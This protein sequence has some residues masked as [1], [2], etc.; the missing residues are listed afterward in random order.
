MKPMK[1]RAVVFR[2][3]RRQLLTRFGAALG[4][5]SLGGCLS[6]YRDIAEDSGDGDGSGGD[7]GSDGDGVTDR[8]FT[9]TDSGC[10]QPASEASVTFD[11]A[12]SSVTV[13]GTIG[14]SNACYTAEL[15]AASYDSESGTLDLTVVS[16]PEEG[17]DACA[18]CIVAIDYEATF[19]FAEGVPRT[20]TVTHDGLDEP[21]VVAEAQSG[22]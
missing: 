6:Q 19:D 15:A 13:T 12:D 20:V 4:T 21:E 17:P 8:T 1:R 14:G 7:T 18:D 9:V 22:E 11:E 10:A 3:N 16:K 2:M 5:A